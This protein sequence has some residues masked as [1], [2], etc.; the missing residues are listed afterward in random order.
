MSRDFAV[1]LNRV[2]PIPLYHQ[3]SGQLVTAIETGALP[4]GSFL[5]NEIELAERWQVSRPTVRRA[6]QDLVDNGMLVRR[7]G[8]GTQVVSDQ[9]RRPFKLSS[10][11]EDLLATGRQP[12]TKVIVLD[13]V[14][15]DA[16]V[17]EALGVGVA[18]DVVRIERL[19]S[20]G[21]QPLAIMRNWLTTEI[22]GSI[23][24]DQLEQRGLYAV[25]RELGVRP[26]SAVQTLGAAAATQ[27]DAAALGLSVGAPLVTM[28]RLMQD[29]TGRP[30]E[31]G[32]HVYDAAHYTVE[33]HVVDT[34]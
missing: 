17:A 20:V 28:R 18:T 5:D 27:A 30:V 21:S 3:L 26:H 9:V 31:L 33:L 4:K 23:T 1:V 32:S 10:L 7:R 15:A 19:R 14:A 25:L 8:V 13:T 24:S 29:D 11:Y 6:I 34:A 12:V 16:E 22:A 2:S